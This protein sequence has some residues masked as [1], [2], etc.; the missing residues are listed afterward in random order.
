MHR[1]F[2]CDRAPG[3]GRRAG[4]ETC[5]SRKWLSWL[6]QQMAPC[7]EPVPPLSPSRSFSKKKKKRIQSSLV[8]NILQVFFFRNQNIYLNDLM[9]CFSFALSLS[10][11]SLFPSLSVIFSFNP[12]P[13]LCNCCPINLCGKLSLA[14]ARRKKKKDRE[15]GW[16]NCS[17]VSQE[18]GE[19]ERERGSA[20]GDERFPRLSFG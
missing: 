8:D 12:S 18:D 1:E 5:K 11:F 7:T 4:Y 17:P 19:Q 9:P 15:R 10:S 20:E 14:I 6:A 16:H 3:C 2:G 13:L